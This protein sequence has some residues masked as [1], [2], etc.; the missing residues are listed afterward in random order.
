MAAVVGP[1]GASAGSGLDVRLEGEDLY[2]S[3]E[4]H[5][6]LRYRQ[7]LVADP[8]GKD[9]LLTTN[10][11][12]HPV[13]APNGA[14]LT[15]HFTPEHPHHRGV[16]SA[17]TK[18]E[19]TLDGETLHPDFWNIH[20][21]TGRTRS[22]SVTP[23]PDGFNA[24]VVSEV[25]RR[26]GWAPVLDEAWEVRFPRRYRRADPDDARSTFVFDITV[27]QNPRI[28]IQLLKYHYGGMA[29]RGARQWKKR[30]DVSVQNSAGKD[31]AGAD[32][33][34]A[35][36]I[37]MSATVDGRLAGISLLEHPANLHAPNGVRMHSDMPYYV[38]ALPQ[39][40]PVT[41]EAG[42]EYLFRY[43]VVAHNGRAERGTLDELWRDFAAS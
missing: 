35:R 42:R 31:R 6:V 5:P 43:R 36:W 38:F 7:R 3:C 8:T 10:G 14:V 30:S 1:G 15:D 27:R 33:T 41:L 21:G 2:A 24:R 26:G 34:R 20:L 39:S 11:Y 16:F 4:G 13:T 40:G 9:P 29:V 32:Q 28:S 25:R 18:T 19:L 12:L 23:A 37:D 17:W 22:V